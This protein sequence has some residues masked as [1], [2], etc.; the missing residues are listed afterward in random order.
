MSTLWEEFIAAKPKAKK[1]ATIPAAA[2]LPAPTEKK[3]DL[4]LFTCC[5]AP[6]FFRAGFFPEEVA[7]VLDL[8]CSPE[9]SDLCK[10]KWDIVEKTELYKLQSAAARNGDVAMLRHLGKA[11]L[12]QDGKPRISD[13]GIGDIVIEI[14]PEGNENG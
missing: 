5:K 4:N 2:Q 6:D 14:P 9:K 13:P 11:I 7:L 10:R 1:A 12:A 3:S 8:P